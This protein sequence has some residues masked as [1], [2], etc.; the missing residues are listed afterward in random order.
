MAETSDRF[1][2][3]AYGVFGNTQVGIGSGPVTGDAEHALLWNGSSASAV[4]LH[5]V[6]FGFSNA[7][8]ASGNTQVGYGF[9]T[10]QGI[11]ALLWNGSA[12]SA[13]DLHPVGF[14]YSF[15]LGVFGNTQVGL[16]LGIATGNQRHA[17]LWNGSS[18]S[19]IDLHPTGFLESFATGASGNT[20]VGYALEATPGGFEEHALL[21]NGSAGS[22]VDLHSLLTGFSDSKATGIDDIT[23]DIVGYGYTP[24]GERHALRWSPNAAAA[25]EPGT[26]AF[27][28]LGGTLIILKRRKH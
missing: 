25:P 6:G 2:S 1:Y 21:W 5:P 15:A 16:G 26:L 7:S 13:I 14:S 11:H 10:G 8:G 18:A 20:Q 27:A 28:L 23:G 19:A 17:L 9:A 12:A 3:A 22:V 4:D 24:N